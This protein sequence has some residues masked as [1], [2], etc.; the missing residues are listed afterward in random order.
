MNRLLK[1]VVLTVYTTDDWKS[2]F[3]GSFS[4]YLLSGAIRPKYSIY[5]QQI[6][7]TTERNKTDGM[8]IWKYSLMQQYTSI[9]MLLRT[10]AVNMQKKCIN[11][12]PATLQHCCKSKREEVEAKT[13]ERVSIRRSVYMNSEIW[14]HNK[15]Q[16]HIASS[17]TIR[18]F[19]Q[20]ACDNSAE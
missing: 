12:N 9:N 6:N 2:N 4:I 5:N 20:N 1:E 14:I 16:S 7:Q 18:R 17:Q 13:Q 19:K 3:L 8:S 10:T 11:T 15:R